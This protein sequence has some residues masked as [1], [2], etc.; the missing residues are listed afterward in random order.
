MK[1]GKPQLVFTKNLFQDYLGKSIPLF[2]DVKITYR[3]NCKCSFC[4]LWKRERLDELSLE[5]HKSLLDQAKELGARLVSYEGGEPLLRADL[6]KILCYAKQKD[7]IVHINTNGLLLEKKA[8]VIMPYLDEIS[9][10][11]DY[12]D[13]EKHDKQRGVAGLYE[14]ALAGIQKVKDKV[15]VTISATITRETTKQDVIMLSK[16]C[17]KM[18]I[19]IS[20]QPV[21]SFDNAKDLT[22]EKDR[23]IE[24]FRLAA[25]LKKDGYPVY[26]LS[27]FLDMLTEETTVPCRAGDTCIF[28]HPDGK[29]SFPCNQWGGKENFVGSVREKT[30]KEIWTSPKVEELRKKARGCSCCY[31]GCTVYLSLATTKASSWVD[32]LKSSTGLLH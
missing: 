24:M 16:L 6:P 22:I 9:V 23:N 27:S 14:K 4:N 31:F 12:F 11:L 30:L 21:F 18:G 17:Q 10:S 7:M 5:E 1:I 3:C 13:K 20:F 28:M 15:P 25:K 19:G 2:L 32:F 26:N 29:V 8:D